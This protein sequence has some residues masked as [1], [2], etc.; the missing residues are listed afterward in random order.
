MEIMIT[1]IL[2]IYG[3]VQGVGFRESMRQEAVRLGISGW[4][5]NRPNGKV[6]ALVYGPSDNVGRMVSWTRKGPPYARVEHVEVLPAEV[7]PPHEFVIR[8]D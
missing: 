7:P 8:F 4:V 2:H 5:C 6:E 3:R 1:R